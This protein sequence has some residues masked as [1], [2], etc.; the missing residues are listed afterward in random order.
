MFLL[1]DGIRYLKKELEKSEAQQ[2]YLNNEVKTL[3]FLCEGS[4]KELKRLILKKQ[5]KLLKGT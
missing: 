1:Q 4:E 2:N 5:V 3:E